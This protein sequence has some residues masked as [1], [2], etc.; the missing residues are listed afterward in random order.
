MGIETEV[1]LIC[2]SP[3]ASRLRLPSVLLEEV[4]SGTAGQP[5]LISLTVV[6]KFILGHWRA[7]AWMGVVAKLP[8]NMSNEDQFPFFILI[9]LCRPIGAAHWILSDDTRLDKIVKGSTSNSLDCSVGCR[10]RLF[11][12]VVVRAH[13][14][15]P[16]Y[17]MWNFPPFFTFLYEFFAPVPL[18]LTQAFQVFLR[19]VRRIFPVDKVVSRHGHIVP[20]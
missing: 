20:L 15:A 11:S 5:S 16:V 4:W 10:K 17:L 13:W 9:G 14:L 1:V 2:R 8:W 6:L 19:D 18:T 7:V 3:Y 12:I